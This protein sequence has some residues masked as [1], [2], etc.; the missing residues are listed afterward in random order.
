MFYGLLLIITDLHEQL[1][2]EFFW[3]KLLIVWDL[4]WVF[5]DRYLEMSP[6]LWLIWFDEHGALTALW[7]AFRFGGPAAYVFTY[8]ECLVSWLILGCNLGYCISVVR[9][10]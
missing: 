7:W 10:T 8:G 1:S 5:F 6:P 3:M 9:Y 4:G 2:P